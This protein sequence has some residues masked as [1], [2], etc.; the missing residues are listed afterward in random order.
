MTKSRL[1]AESKANDLQAMYAAKTTYFN[2]RSNCIEFVYK[3]NWDERLKAS[4]PSLND[5]AIKCVGIN[6]NGVAF[7]GSPLDSGKNE[8]CFFFQ[9]SDERVVKQIMDNPALLYDADFMK[10][11]E[12][13]LA[14]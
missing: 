2:K 9:Y 14:I 3:Y 8:G 6:A 10:S 5:F 13:I 1:Y 12:V 4:N 7:R 11:R